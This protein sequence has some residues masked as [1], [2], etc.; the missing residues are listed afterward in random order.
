MIE[1]KFKKSEV[2]LIPEDWELKLFE[3]IC[4]TKSGGTPS[5]EVKEFFSGNIPWVTTGELNDGYI[6][7]TTE[8]I[9][10]AAVVNSSAKVFPAGTLLMA[11]YGATIGKLGITKVDAATNQACCAIFLKNDEQ[12]Y[13][14]YKLLF[15]RP[16]LVAKG[17]GAGQPNISQAVIKKLQ[18]AFP[19]KTEQSRIADALS[20]IDDLISTTKK[21]IEKK[22]NIKEG[23]MQD[24]LSGK[25]R[26]KKFET[27]KKL[28]QTSIGFIPCNWEIDK[29]GEQFEFLPN[30]TLPRE[31]M[32]DNGVVQNIHYGDVLIKFGSIVDVQKDD[33]PYISNPNF[34][35]NYLIKDGDVIIAD[36]AED[37]TV[38]KATEIT[39]VADN[40][41]VSGLHT[42]WLHPINKGRYGLG[43]LGYAFNARIY[44]NQLLPL[45]QGTKVTS[46]SKTA[47][48]DTYL[49]VP[50]KSEQEAIVSTLSAMD[51]EIQSL[52]V[53]L[54]KYQSL[55]QGMMQQLLTGKIRLI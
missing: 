44:H 43:F 37:E 34:K 21:L 49:V 16:Q 12:K 36:T 20:D 26:I 42:M 47:I 9:S 45:M 10:E 15:D 46:I 22:R 4:S 6:Y 39:N 13:V 30:N 14:F 24:L 7:D 53:R 1:T 41:I 19:S 52:E 48:Q 55:K 28:K 23:A 8:H 11:M 27:D 18:Y 2:G 31:E 51:E 17:Y 29:I 38:G 40:K 33:V 5:R 3:D 54:T 32:S 50:P 25:R 35:P